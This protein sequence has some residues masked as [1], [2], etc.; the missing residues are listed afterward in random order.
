MSRILN[1]KV[2]YTWILVI[3]V[4]TMIVT[5]QF[6]E[7][8]PL[9]TRIILGIVVSLLFLAA[10]A[11]REVV[12]GMAAFH[13]EKP[14]KKTTLFLFGGVYPENRDE[15]VTTHLRLHYLARFLV[16]IIIVAVFYGLYATFIVA[17]NL[18]L[19]GVAQWLA[20]VSFLLFLL[21]LI[22]AFPLDGG[23]ILR[24]VIWRSKGDYYKATDIASR[25]GWAIGLF[26]IFAGV[27]VFIV[28]HEWIISLLIITIGWTIEIA[29]GYTRREINTHWV[30]QNIKAEDIMTKEYPAMPQQVSIG[31][32][33]RERI[34]IKGWPY[35]LVVDGTKLKGILTLKQ[36]K[37]VPG[38]RWN[39]TVIGDV[40]TPCDQ[41]S[42]AHL[43][44]SADTLF[45]EMYRRGVDYMPILEDDNLV[46]VVNR[47]AL[48]SLIKTR[49]GFGA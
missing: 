10:V 31:Q 7:H 3:A 34:L 36:V 26:L 27:L 25:T 20:Y 23:Q 18:M 44:Q 6:S 8:Y 32:L 19:A 33:V 46:G 37:S 11:I 41:I 43:Q 2:H 5:T 40:M 9:L 28:S 35:I 4:L 39:D 17:G 45:E 14:F 12:L 1:I 48:T 42:T 29:A 47:V 22:P 38:N 16:N 21:H 13:K 24:M 49:I 30:L 15:I